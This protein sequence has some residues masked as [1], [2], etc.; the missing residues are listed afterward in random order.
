MLLLILYGKNII[1]GLISNNNIK[2]KKNV[3]YQKYNEIDWIKL[4]T[5]MENLENRFKHFKYIKIK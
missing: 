1:I 4:I 5:F 3:Q 2:K